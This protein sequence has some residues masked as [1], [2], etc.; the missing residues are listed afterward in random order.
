MFCVKR[1][2][3]KLRIVLGSRMP[4]EINHDQISLA[5]VLLAPIGTIRYAAFHNWFIACWHYDHL[6]Y[7]LSGLQHDYAKLPLLNHCNQ[8]NPAQE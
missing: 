4:I 1:L 8:I 7:I 3:R 6:D 5:N 2:A